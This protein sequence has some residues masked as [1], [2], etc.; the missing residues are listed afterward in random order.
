MMLAPSA[1]RILLLSAAF[2]VATFLVGWGGVVVVAIAWG[3]MA[4]YIRAA[5]IQAGASAMI[6]WALLLALSAS[7]GPVG[8]LAA[9]LGGIMGA[10]AAALIALSLIFPAALAWAGARA[11]AGL[12]AL[13]TSRES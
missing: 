5:G 13:A 3:I 10:P 7:R 6:G 2:A 4:R 1:L 8:H 11:A 12:A 9:T